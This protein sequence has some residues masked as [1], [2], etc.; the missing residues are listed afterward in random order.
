MQGPDPDHSF[1][2]K[3]RPAVE[4]PERC[5][6]QLYDIISCHGKRHECRA[7]IREV[8]E[9]T[10][11]TPELFQI[12]IKVGAGE[13]SD[14]VKVCDVGVKVYCKIYRLQTLLVRFSRNTEHKGRT[15]FQSHLPGCFHRRADLR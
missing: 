1:E 13:R 3:R 8:R 6:A 11:E 9:F 10:R 2:E 14:G 12:I 7:L 5:P 4:S 15:Y